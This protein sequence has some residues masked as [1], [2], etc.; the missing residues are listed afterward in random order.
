MP[1]GTR[2]PRVPKE[3]HHSP[4]FQALRNR[5]QDLFGRQNNTPEE[6]SYDVR[7]PTLG[8]ADLI[9]LLPPD[10]HLRPLYRYILPLCERRQLELRRGEFRAADD[11]L[12]SECRYSPWDS[13]RSLLQIATPL[14]RDPGCGSGLSGGLRGGL[15][16]QKGVR[17]RFRDY[18]GSQSTARSCCLTGRT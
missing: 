10:C 1:R 13:Y 18:A 7:S 2:T 3:N 15:C 16:L 11:D 8:H 4:K 14:V 17:G 5:V 6:T 12:C 9:N